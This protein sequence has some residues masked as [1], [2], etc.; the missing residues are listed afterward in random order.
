MSDATKMPR[1]QPIDDAA[2]AAVTGGSRDGGRSERD[3]DSNDYMGGTWQSDVLSGGGGDDTIMGHGGN[4]FI[5]GGAGADLIDGGEG[6]DRITW[7][8]GQGND[9]IN[10]GDGNDALTLNIP[11]MSL[12]ELLASIE[13]AEGSAAPFVN[14]ATINVTG[15]TGTLVIGDE[16][17][18]FSNLESLRLVMELR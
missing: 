5:A 17:I 7:A 4:D 10:G 16:R 1:M 15:V 12:E 2:L 11:G 9:T 18:S 8:T 14:G 13:L 3:P 6:D